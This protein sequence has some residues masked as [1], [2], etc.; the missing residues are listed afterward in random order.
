MLRALFALH[1]LRF[2]VR[3]AALSFCIFVDS[4]R[5][6]LAKNLLEPQ[7]AVAD[8]QRRDFLTFPQ[9]GRQ[10][11]SPAMRIELHHRRQPVEH[12]MPLRACV[13]R[14][15][16]SD[17]PRC[18]TGD[19]FALVHHENLVRHR[20]QFFQ[21]VLGNNDRRAQL[22]VDTIDNLEEFTCRDRIEL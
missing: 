11:R 20:K 13:A 18:I 16:I 1:F 7:S 10:A 6:R 14:Q 3:T 12:R 4:P 5:L 21:T 17:F 8:C 9:E 2:F 22:T 15:E 19:Q